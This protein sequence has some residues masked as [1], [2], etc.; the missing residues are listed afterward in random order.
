MISNMQTNRKSVLAAKQLG[1]ALRHRRKE[2]GLT[3][4][5]LA[6]KLN[7]DVGQLSRFERAEFKIVSRN[8]QKVAAFLQIQVDDGVGEPDCIVE[9]FAELLGRSARHRAAA[10]ALVRA[11]QELR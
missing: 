6:S 1:D 5:Q 11:L 2:L 8:L 7:V 3:L 4:E 10:I 9:Q